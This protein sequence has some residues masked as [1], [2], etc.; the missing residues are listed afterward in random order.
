MDMELTSSNPEPSSF[1]MATMTKE[2]DNI[3]Q[4]LSSDVQSST[5]GKDI[6]RKSIHQEK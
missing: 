2:L 6:P 5:V 4:A 1:L 3:V